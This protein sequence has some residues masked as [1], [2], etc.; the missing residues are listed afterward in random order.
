M[1]NS[2]VT[3]TPSI[4]PGTDLELTIGM[5]RRLLER[6]PEREGQAKFKARATQ[7]EVIRRPKARMSQHIHRQ[8]IAVLAA[9]SVKQRWKC[10]VWDIFK[11]FLK[12]DVSGKSF[13]K[14]FLREPQLPPGEFAAGKGIVYHLL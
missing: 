1:A 6:K 12:S 14:I 2:C 4:G 9:A 7:C 13:C 11:A 3:I 10:G 8:S 5:S